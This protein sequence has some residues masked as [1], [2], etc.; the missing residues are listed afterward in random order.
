MQEK[1][2][3]EYAVIRIVPRV[4]REEFVNVGVIMYC[5]RHRWVKTMIHMDAN[6]IRSLCPDADIE[7]MHGYLQSFVDIVNG[8]P[9]AGRIAAFEASER[10]RWLTSI[11]SSVIQTSRPHPGMCIDPENQLRKIF[12]DS[13]L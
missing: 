4:E 1:L 10:F 13:V 5:K 8:K 7:D 3:F 12:E 11:R 2:L 6:K 9:S